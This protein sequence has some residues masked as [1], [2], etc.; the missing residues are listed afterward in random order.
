MSAQG[1]SPSLFADPSRGQ[2]L[3]LRAWEFVSTERHL[4]GVLE[5]VSDVLLSAVPFQS[6]GI[7]SFHDGKHDLYAMHLVGE[8]HREG[9]SMA[10]FMQ[11]QKRPERRDLPSKPLVPIHAEMHRNIQAGIPY[12]CDDIFA[13]DAWFEHD[14]AL[15]S[16]GVR[17]YC[18]V[19]LLVRTNLIGVAVFSRHEAI[20]FTGD[21]LNILSDV[22]RALAVAVNN[23]IAN[24]EIRKLRDRLE[25]ENAALRSALGQVPWTHELIG[26]TLPLKR[27]LSAI[28]QVAE[29]DATILIT[30][31]TGTGKEL[32]ARA[33]HRR[34]ARANG[35]LI[36]VNCSAIPETLLASELFGHERGAFTGAAERRKG[37]FEQAH[38]GTLF[39]D[40][41]GE[42]P[43]ET[44]IML[45]RVLQE[46][47]FERLGGTQTVQVDVRIVA[48]TNQGLEQQ[49]AEGK[50][51]SDLYYRL[52]VFPIHVPSLRDRIDDVPLLIG[53]FADKYAKRFGR[54]I[55]RIEA[56]TS[57]RMQ[58]YAWPGNVRELENIVERAVILTRDGTLRIDPALLPSGGPEAGIE[59]RLE[60]H[61]REAIV[62][63]LRASHG[64]V[65]GAGGAAKKLGIPA[66]TLEFRIRRLR[67]DKF[68]Y[69]KDMTEIPQA[70]LRR[71]A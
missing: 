47:E 32:V 14:F 27:V 22:S 35:P 63:A 29:T 18:S 23:A 28:E 11:R 43:P 10:E 48:A 33:I 68:Q 21:E 8:P 44:Q 67:I 13:K 2:A 50:F 12:S 56:G 15:A 59:Q 7:V 38:G 30:G 36:K 51:R 24:E 37:R 49:V 9:E 4:Q 57:Q 60:K 54:K 62:A 39:L 70:S 52:N 34:S 5:A 25:A 16:G 64:R 31:E 71:R 65:S 46:R 69:R 19:P 66:S 45:L 17:A 42:M 53:H 3:A 1:A 41:V 40:E 20:G 6:L 58:A 55:A 61:E 26:N